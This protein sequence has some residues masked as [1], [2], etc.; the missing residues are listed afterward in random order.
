MKSVK[1][2]RH[3]LCAWAELTVVPVASSMLAFASWGHVLVKELSGLY[4]FKV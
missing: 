2:Q 4:G 3:S 1:P